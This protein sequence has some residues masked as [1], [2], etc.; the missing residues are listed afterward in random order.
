MIDYILLIKLLIAHLIGDFFLQPKNWV[1]QKRENSYKSVF[2]YLHS[3]VHAILVYI[4]VFDFRNWQIPLII[5][6][7]HSIIDSIKSGTKNDNAKGFVVDQILH[8]ITLIIIWI[9]YT[10]SWEQLMNEVGILLASRSAWAII[11]GYLIILNPFAFFIGKLTANWQKQIDA[12]G[13]TDAGKYIGMLERFL[14]LTFMLLGSYEAIGFLLAAK[15]VFRFGDL[16]EAKDRKKTE[17]ILI[18]TLL[19]FALTIALGLF[20]LF[21]LNGKS[22]F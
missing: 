14:V 1:D 12:D 22:S 16:K 8:I 7:S 11:L 15:S 3:L 20:V 17:Y 6:I 4:I 18:G 21:L 13:L 19:S 10:G 9:I 5:F 2:L